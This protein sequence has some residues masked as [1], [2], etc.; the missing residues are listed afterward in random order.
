M[1]AIV[2]TDD[3]QQWKIKGLAWHNYESISLV[4]FGSVNI[5]DNWIKLRIEQKIKTTV[6]AELSY[7]LLLNINVN[8]GNP[9]PFIWGIG[10]CT[11]KAL[12]Q[13]KRMLFIGKIE[14]S[15][16]QGLEI[17]IVLN[18]VFGKFL[19]LFFLDTELNVWYLER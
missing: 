12:I 8:K 7:V 19:T 10:A 18:S 3:R 4:L 17:R 16:K 15:Q 5:I 13:I 9:L 6:L 2:L 11:Q 1:C 14:W